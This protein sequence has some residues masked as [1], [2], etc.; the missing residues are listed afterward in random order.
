MG[1]LKDNKRDLSEFQRFSGKQQDTEE[2]VR[3]FLEMICLSSKHIFKIVLVTG[4]L[5]IW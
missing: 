2:Y 4:A 3:D 5:M 1:D